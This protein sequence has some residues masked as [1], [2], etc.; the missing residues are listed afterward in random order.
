MRNTTFSEYVQRMQEL[1]TP[2]VDTDEETPEPTPTPAAGLFGN[3]GMTSDAMP[4]FMRAMKQ[5]L[6]ARGV[7]T[8][9]DEKKAARKILAVLRTPIA[10]LKALG[11]SANDIAMAVQ[12]VINLISIGSGGY[13]GFNPN[14]VRGAIQKSQKPEPEPENMG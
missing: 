4:R 10:R 3:T 12:E 14:R 5:M 8:G 11:L 9:G 6:T 13:T 1:A 7:V 2:P